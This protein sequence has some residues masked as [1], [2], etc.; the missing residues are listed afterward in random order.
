MG[1]KEVLSAI[2][3]QGRLT[4]LQ[5]KA[6]ED[7]LDSQGNKLDHFAE[8]VS[9]NRA[10]IKELSDLEREHSRRISDVDTKVEKNSSTIKEV[11][12]RPAVQLGKTVKRLIAG[13]A[14]A[15]ITTAFVVFWDKIAN[16]FKGSG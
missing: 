12:D 13:G 10:S 6:L 4:K 3:N 16:L 8:D 2:A 14:A 11:S 1:E 5:L 9:L 15:V 7:K